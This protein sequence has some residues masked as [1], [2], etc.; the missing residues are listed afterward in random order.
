MPFGMLQWG[1]DFAAVEMFVMDLDV[2]PHAARF[3]GATTVQPWKCQSKEKREN[4]LIVL[5]WG[6]DFAAVEMLAVL[7]DG[8]KGVAVLQ[9]GHD[10]AAVEI[11]PG[12]CM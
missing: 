5:Q 1:H 3:N 8:A 6:H 10:F 2:S 9:W 12:F 4:W 7:P 11:A